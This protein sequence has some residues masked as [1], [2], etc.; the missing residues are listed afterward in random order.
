MVAVAWQYMC[1]AGWHEWNAL[2]IYACRR[3]NSM[4]WTPCADYR[5]IGI[6]CFGHPSVQAAW[7]MGRGDERVG[8]DRKRNEC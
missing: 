3:A 5:R 6:A 4:V 1:A 7:E 2:G 8:G